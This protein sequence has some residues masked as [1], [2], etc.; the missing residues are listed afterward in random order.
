MPNAESRYTAIIG[1]IFAER[2]EPGLRQIAF[3]REDIVRTATKLDIPLPK[4][5]GDLVYS[6]RYRSP[7]PPQVL[8]TAPKGQTWIIRPAGRGRYRLH[9]LTKC[10][11]SRIRTWRRPKCRTPRRA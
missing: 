9:W 10:V 2:H 1:D 8:Q 6:F 3:D 11:W 4:N 5:I 7:L